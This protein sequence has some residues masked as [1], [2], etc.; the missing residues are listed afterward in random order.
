MPF[1]NYS[2]ANLKC[3]QCDN[4]PAWKTLEGTADGQ[5]SESWGVLD[6]SNKHPYHWNLCQSCWIKDSGCDCESDDEYSVSQSGCDNLTCGNPIIYTDSDFPDTDSEA[7]EQSWETLCLG[8][9]GADGIL[10][11]DFCEECESLN[12]ALELR[13][14]ANEMPVE[15][16]D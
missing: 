3:S 13:E 1:N 2:I 14:L 12:E 5:K 15:L 11:G 4:K 10:E 7:E 6:Y 8:G 9:C 16:R